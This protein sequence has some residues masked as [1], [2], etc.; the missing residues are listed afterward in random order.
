M[1]TIDDLDNQTRKIILNI[2]DEI[3]SLTN[4]DRVA[5]F[6]LIYNRYCINCGIDKQF[7]CEY[8]KIK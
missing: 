1:K 2:E 8:S 3:E 4:E 7:H 6:S 5:L